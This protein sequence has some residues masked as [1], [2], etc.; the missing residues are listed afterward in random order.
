MTN[1]NKTLIA[2][3]IDRSGSMHSIKDDTE[4]GYAAF[5]GEQLDA[6][7][8]D[9]T[10]Q[11][12]LAQFDSEY[13]VVFANHDLKELPQYRLVPRGSTALVDSLYR[14]VQQVGSDLDKLPEEERPGKVIIV[15][16]TDGHENASREVTAETLKAKIE[17]QKEKYSWDFLFL[18]ANIDAVSVGA[19]YG[20]DAGASMTY[21][22]NSEGVTANFKAASRMTSALRGGAPMAAAAFTDEERMAAMGEPLDLSGG[23][24]SLD[25]LAFGSGSA[26]SALVV[27]K[28]GRGKTSVKRS[29]P[30]GTDEK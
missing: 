30:K 4:G 18:G 3:L 19:M 14:L 24:G 2:F 13:E 25:P 26:P 11:V 9:E 27:G 21:G 23:G 16:L 5:L 17:E 29:S 15:T 6:L 12:T 1:P 7:K 28:P 22:A 20:F 8:D 10:V